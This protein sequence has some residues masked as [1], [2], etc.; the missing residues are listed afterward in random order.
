MYEMWEI[1]MNKHIE[2]LIQKLEAIQNKCLLSED[3]GTIGE[4]IG[5]LTIQFL[6]E[7]PEPDAMHYENVNGIASYW[8][9]YK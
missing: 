5:H 2:E 3:Q 1:K 4:A 9:F 7:K 6:A 8:E